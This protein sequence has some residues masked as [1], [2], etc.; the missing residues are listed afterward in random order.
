[1]NYMKELKEKL[2]TLCIFRDLLKDPVIALLRSYLDNPTSSVYAEF[3]SS[4]YEANGG[5]LGEYIKELTTT[6][7]NVYVRTAGSGRNIPSYMYN[8]LT[9]E[10]DILQETAELSKNTLCDSLGYQGFL[11]EFTTTRLRLKDIYLHR[12][13]NIGKYGYGI[14]AKNRMF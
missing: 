6:S 5:N 8:T 4:L 13:E 10:L 7:E 1:M 12:A 2:D 11:P 9:S 14:Y 3:V